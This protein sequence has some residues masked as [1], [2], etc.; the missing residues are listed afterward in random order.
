MLLWVGIDRG[1]VIE[2]D[3]TGFFFG[4]ASTLE[5]KLQDEARDFV[6]DGGCGDL[7]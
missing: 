2:A 6:D 5:F 4:G 3:E 7:D 1:G